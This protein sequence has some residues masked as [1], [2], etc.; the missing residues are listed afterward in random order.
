MRLD[1]ANV[2]PD[3]AYHWLIA[4]IVPR[5]IAWVST[6]NEDDSANLAPFSFFTG[7]TSEPLTCLICVGRHKDGRK[8]D[9]WRNVER[10]REHVIHVVSD[11]LAQP[12][13]VTSVAFPYGVDE[14]AAAGVTKA[15]SEKVAPPRIAEAPIAMECRLDRIVEIGAPG[16][17]T[18]IIIGEVLL[19][20]VHDDLLVNGRID[21]GRVDA[22]G[23]TS[24]AGY[25]RTRDRFDMVRPK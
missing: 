21:L 7:I 23:R 15:P 12:M 25:V 3:A 11:A 13:N 1:P 22:I 10:T 19:W 8:K 2:S 6:L 18:A 9:T 24:G 16:D 14:F 5:P 4:S 17:E 20:H